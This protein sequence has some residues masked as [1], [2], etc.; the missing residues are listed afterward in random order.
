MRRRSLSASAR[1]FPS[2]GSSSS[3]AGENQYRIR[4]CVGLARTRGQGGGWGCSAP[5]S[6]PST[7]SSSRAHCQTLPDGLPTTTWP[8]DQR[9][10]SRPNRRQEKKTRF[11]I[12]EDCVLAVIW[13]CQAVL[14]PSHD[15]KKT[16]SHYNLLQP[17]HIHGSDLRCSDLI[18]ERFARLANDMK[19]V[20]PFV[21][22]WLVGL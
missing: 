9:S 17:S 13:Q 15:S 12:G 5:H 14:N 1:P 21:V 11:H 3:R 10:L 7:A 18:I 22:I 16:G 19:N 6:I 4:I 2:A 20:Q 8:A